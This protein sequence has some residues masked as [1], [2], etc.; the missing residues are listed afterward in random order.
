M[1]KNILLIPL[2]IIGLGTQAWA[3]TKE[4]PC[5]NYT[6]KNHSFNS[7]GEKIN[8]G[9]CECGQ[10]EV[11]SSFAW[12]VFALYDFEET[13]FPSYHV[14][15]EDYYDVKAITMCSDKNDLSCEA[16]HKADLINGTYYFKNNNAT[17]D[18]FSCDLEIGI[19]FSNP[20]KHI[21]GQANIPDTNTEKTSNIQSITGQ[22]I[23]ATPTNIQTTDSSGEAS[24]VMAIV[25]NTDSSTTIQ[26]ND[27]SVVEVQPKT[28]TSFNPS[29][30]VDGEI[31]NNISLIRGEIGLTIDCA[32]LGGNSYSVKTPTGTISIDNSCSATRR[33]GTT[34]VK[35]TANYSQTGLD[36]HLNVSVTTG[37]V[38][39]TAKDGSTTA[40]SAGQDK[41]INE[42]VSY[43][44]WVL[45][46]DG[47]KIYGGKVNQLV[48]TSYPG[49]VS[50]LLEY[51]FPNPIFS[52]DNTKTAEFSTTI[53]ITDFSTYEDLIIYTISLSKGLDG[54]IVE[55][56]IF[57]V[58]ANGSIIAESVSSDRFTVTWKDL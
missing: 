27:G 53:P 17:N 52:D 6:V 46:I 49:A 35:F 15:L 33:E 20:K 40:L 41:S 47:D 19:G 11:S 1:N 58:D 45:P 43:T 12:S 14:A 26:R 24:D 48:W 29:T 44:S 8:H 42:L 16:R 36:G 28:I 54:K 21:P 22:V 2:L 31:I 13:I 56:R 39:V 10:V 18:Y 3:E 25:T 23:T 7:E 55:A 5:V 34:S 38:I 50:Y 4:Y 30:Q 37:S 57:A 51:N 9:F 32:K